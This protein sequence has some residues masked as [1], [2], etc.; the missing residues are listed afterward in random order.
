MYSTILPNSRYGPHWCSGD[1]IGVCL[2]MDAGTLAYQRNGQPLG[3]AFDSIEHGVG[4]ALFPAASLGHRESLTANFGGTPFRFP[5]DGYE[6]MQAVPHERLHNAG[7]L[8]RYTVALAGQ[9]RSAA[10]RPASAEQPAGRSRQAVV[11]QQ[12]PSPAAVHLV[13]AGLLVGP[14]KRLLDDPYV[15]EDKVFACVQDM[16]AMK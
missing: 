8:L 1:I 13:V 4:I 7:V 12:R 14:L 10:A 16:C 15:I 6:P 5:V 11:A 3:E 2:D 9:I